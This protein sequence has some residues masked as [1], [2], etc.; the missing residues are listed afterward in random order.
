MTRILVLGAGF[1]GLELC[2]LLSEALGDSIEVT[3]IEKNDHFVF[4]FSKLDIMF[5]HAQPQAV[6]LAYANFAK[7]GVQLIKQT[8][9]KID[10]VTKRVTTNGASYAADYLVVA[11][12][13]DYDWDATPGL[14]EVNEFY[15][16]AG[17][18]RLRDALS[19]FTQGHALI[20]VCGA[21][22]KCPP[23]PSECALMLHDYLEHKGVRDACEISFVLPLPSPVPPSPET[24]Q[25]LIAAFAERNIK[26]HPSKRVVVIDTPRRIASLDDGSEI[27]FDLFLGV[28]KHRVPSVVLNSGLAENGWVT[29]NPRTLETKYPGVY[30]V[31]DGANTGTPKAG[32]FAEG[33][34]KAVASALIAKIGSGGASREFDGFGTCYIEFGGGRVGKVEVDFFSGPK[35]IGMYYEPSLGLRADKE[36]FVSSRRARWFGIQTLA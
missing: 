12:G 7:S 16:T 32:V 24:S 30:A 5:G 10:P 31:G 36:N 35:P 19:H 4:G 25:A 14:A 23:A 1:G 22:Y 26:F 8:I 28:P 2:T 3:L 15:T 33:A 21:P 34:A 9:T 18:E 6:R 27:A 11:L 17:A 29:V 20:G 13:A